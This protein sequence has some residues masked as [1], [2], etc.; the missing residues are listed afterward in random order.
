M[1]EN[2]IEPSKTSDE[3]A[4]IFEEAYLYAYPLMLL[5]HVKRM[6]TNTEYPTYEKAPVNQLFHAHELMTPKMRTLTRGNVD[7]VYSQ[8][9]LDLK[10]EPIVMRKPATDRYCSVQ[11]FDGYSNTPVILGTG[12]LGGSDQH[13]Y[14][15]VGPGWE[16]T[17]PE[18]VI[19]V[20][21]QTNLVWLLIRTKLLGPED[22]ENVYAIQQAMDLQPLSAYGTDYTPPKGVYRPDYDYVAIEK[23]ASLSVQEYFELFNELAIDNPA[24]P[25]DEPALQRFAP[26]NIGAGLTFDFDALDPEIQE[27]ISYLPN[28]LGL[29]FSSKYAKTIDSNGWRFLDESVGQFGTDYVF[30]AIVAYGGFANP[31]SMAVYP[32]MS[33]KA[34]GTPLSG[35]KNYVLHFEPGMLPPHG[36]DGWWSLTA[37]SGPGYVIENEL[38]RYN[39]SDSS[40]LKF[41]EDGSLDLYIQAKNPQGEK[42]S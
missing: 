15:L 40:D 9:Y 21:V 19:E 5:E 29:E 20:P 37:Y 24:A 10:A 23:V 14:A 4:S 26:W 13:D 34:S 17:L 28:L 18:G 30:R 36:K 22:I 2:A 31:V 12:A 35:D 11:L 32:S 7:T 27:A 41:N 3:I 16:G 1:D 38:D 42:E 6:A 33:M 25:E 39:I 8:T